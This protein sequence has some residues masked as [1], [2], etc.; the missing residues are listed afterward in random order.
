M[1]LKKILGEMNL[2]VVTS[3]N[4]ESETPHCIISIRGKKAAEVGIKPGDIFKIERR[5]SEVVLTPV[6]VDIGEKSI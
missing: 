2:L 6:S 1:S 3:T 4:S 5:G